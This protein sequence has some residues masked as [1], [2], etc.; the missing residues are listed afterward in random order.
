MTRTPRRSAPP[1][2]AAASR[3]TGTAGV[4]G[5]LVVLAGFLFLAIPRWSYTVDDA[6]ITFRYSANWATGLG[7]YFNAG[8][9]VEGYSNFLMMALVSALIRMGGPDVAMPAA[10][11]IGLVSAMGALVGSWAAAR[12]LARAAGAAEREAGMTG[13]VAAGL[14]ALAP[15]FAVNA[16]SGL[17]TMLFSSLVTWGTHGFASGRPRRAAFAW[18]LAALTR[19][20]APFMFTVSWFL[21]V[22][23]GTRSQAAGR[24][25]AAEPSPPHS[26][27]REWLVPAA[28]GFGIIGAHLLFR[29]FCYDG[30]WLPNTFHA[31]QGGSGDRVSYVLTGALPPV[32][33]VAGALLA[34]VGWIVDRRSSRS[35]IV[36]GGVALLGCVL[37]F[38]AGG[39]WMLGHRLIVPY[40]PLLAAFVS[41]GWLRLARRL[42]GNRSAWVSIALLATLA[43]AWQTQQAERRDLESAASL[44]ATGARTG[45]GALADWLRTEARSGDTIA[46]MDIGLIGY[47]NHEQRI[48]DLTGLTDRHIARSPGTF[49]AKRF[50]LDYV[51]R[52][53]P[54]WIVLSFLASGEPYSPIA[55]TQAIHPFSEIEQRLVEHEDFAGHY[56]ESPRAARSDGDELDGLAARLGARKVFRSAATGHHYL[57]AVYGRRD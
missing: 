48:L 1:A 4:I 15:G 49:M 34:L 3:T 56:L 9:H 19:P 35:A 14:I 27:P 7:P 29:Y 33:G 25:A 8:E 37:P 40:L 42:L 55:P 21:Y 31:K 22:L 30:E 12:Y 41:V 20:E 57:L 17:E 54:R 24:S 36:V 44:T 47:R 11:C 32:L 23:A 16:S 13:I 50:D 28:I 5:L 51:F 52:Q 43:V 10:K 18:G 39:D 53:R 26:K 45:H 6:W 38:Y 2:G 46:L